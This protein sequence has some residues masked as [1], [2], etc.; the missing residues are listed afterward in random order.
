MPHFARHLRP[1]WKQ[2]ATALLCLSGCVAPQPPTHIRHWAAYYDD[3][4]APEDFSDLDLVVFD[5]IHHPALMPLKGR[6]HLLAYISIG[7][8]KDGSPEHATSIENHLILEKNAVWPSHIVNVTAPEWRAAAQGFDGVMLDT[9]DSPLYYA[10]TKKPEGYEET[11]IAL[12]GIVRAIRAAHPTMKIMINRGFS[13]LPLVA[14][15]IDYVLAE[16][17]YSN[18]NVSSGQFALFAPN[19]YHQVAEQLQAL[20]SIAPHLQIFT[21]DYWNMDDVNGLERIYTAQRA[22]GFIP[23]ITTPDLRHFTPEPMFLRQHR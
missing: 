8:V 3:S 6:T 4:A 14:N 10:E 2:L 16:S 19:T 7:E 17:I 15:D 20:G 1:C 13:I 5:R 22:Q 18:T 11:R 12:V 21:L 23:Y 9:A